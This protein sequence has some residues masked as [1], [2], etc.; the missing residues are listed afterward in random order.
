MQK[1]SAILRTIALCLVVLG[2]F[3]SGCSSTTTPAQETGSVQIISSPSGAEVY[4]DNEYHGTTP[5]T[6]TAIPAGSHPLE[7]RKPG[8]ERWSA[9]VIVTKGSAANISVVLVSMPTTLPVIFATANPPG[10]KNNLPQIHVDGYWTLPPSA[11]TAN[12]TPLLVH[13]DSFNVGYTDTREVTVSANLYYEGRMVCW[14]TVYL[15]TL[16]VGDHVTKDIM[17]SCTLPSNLNSPDLIVRF[18]NVVVTP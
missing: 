18:E 8:Y 12:P 15:G 13:I 14:N 7:I 16:K 3:L 9:P 4:L 10:A 2:V 1:V 11:G 5:T 6:I 17:V